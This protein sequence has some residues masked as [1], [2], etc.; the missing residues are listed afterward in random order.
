MELTIES[1]STKRTL[2]APFRVCASLDDFRELRD[3]LTKV[4]LVAENES[5]AASYGWLL[6]IF[7]PFDARSTTPALSWGEA[8]TAIPDQT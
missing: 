7:P 2:T 6:T 3:E 5:T 8:G 4:I 1:E